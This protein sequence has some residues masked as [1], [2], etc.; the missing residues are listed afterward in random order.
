M[1]V[2]YRRASATD[3]EKQA[4][5]AGV[6]VQLTSNGLELKCIDINV[7]M[8]VIITTIIS[9]TIYPVELLKLLLFPEAEQ[10]CADSK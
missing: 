1:L 4:V 6:D 9:R 2:N 7:N 10:R 3:H 8:N 5:A